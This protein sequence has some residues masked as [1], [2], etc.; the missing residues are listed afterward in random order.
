M[1]LYESGARPAFSQK[2]RSRACN[3]RVVACHCLFYGWP[4][5]GAPSIDPRSE[6]HNNGWPLENGFE[7]QRELSTLPSAEPCHVSGL[8]DARSLRPAA[9]RPR[10]FRRR[11]LPPAALQK[12]AGVY[13]F[14]ARSVQTSLMP[15]FL[16]KRAAAKQRRVLPVSHQPQRARSSGFRWSQGVQTLPTF[17]PQLHVENGGGSFCCLTGFAVRSQ[18]A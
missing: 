16:S 18:T 12:H 3:C 2:A 1:K 7:V 4:C 17:Q 5:K 15:G 6:K 13:E 10:R 8:R 9:L 14:R 11:R